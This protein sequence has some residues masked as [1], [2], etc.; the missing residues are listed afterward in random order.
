ME[1]KVGEMFLDEWIKLNEF[2]RDN[3]NWESH[4]HLVYVSGNISAELTDTYKGRKGDM[5]QVFKGITL[6][7]RDDISPE[8]RSELESI[9]KL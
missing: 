3:Y 5:H 1:I 8:K 2:I 7:V 6:Q 9:I 4:Y